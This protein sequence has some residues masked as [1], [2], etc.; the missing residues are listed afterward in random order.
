MQIAWLL[1][2]RVFKCLA[3]AH[4]SD[5]TGRRQI[6]RSGT[7]AFKHCVALTKSCR[8]RWVTVDAFWISN[9]CYFIPCPNKHKICHIIKQLYI[10][11]ITPKQENN[12]LQK[13]FLQSQHLVPQPGMPIRS[14]P[15][16]PFRTTLIAGDVFTPDR[17]KMWSSFER[18]CLW[19]PWN[20]S[21]LVLRWNTTV[22]STS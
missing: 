12:A 2:V 13:N 16:S 7:V 14:P 10:E 17:T 3:Q 21:L 20:K 11:N 9:H 22:L 1:W 19:N 5:N 15:F 18:R 6:V 8:E 4:S